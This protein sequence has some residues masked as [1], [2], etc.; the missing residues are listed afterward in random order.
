MKNFIIKYTPENDIEVR[1]YFNSNF[2]D[3]KFGFPFYTWYYG[4]IDN[5]P[6]CYNSIP[7]MYYTSLIIDS[8]SEIDIKK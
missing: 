1:N 4:V 6:I 5:Q 8:I 2:P 7:D 3:N